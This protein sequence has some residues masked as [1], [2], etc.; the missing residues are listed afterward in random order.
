MGPN[1]FPNDGNDPIEAFTPRFR[2][3]AGKFE[4]LDVGLEVE[5][6]APPFLSTLGAWRSEGVPDVAMFFRR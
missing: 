5:G 1:P 4:G 3:F 2:R 6:N